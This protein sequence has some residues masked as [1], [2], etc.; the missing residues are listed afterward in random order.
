MVF[1]P[2]IRRLLS[3]SCVL[4]ILIISPALIE[5][6]T[7]RAQFIETF[8]DG[9]F[10]S[11]PAWIGEV[12]RW[13][14][15]SVDGPA[16]QSAG[17][18]APDTIYLA[19]ASAAS[20]GSWRFTFA[21]RGVNL[22][23]FNGARIFF[24]A[25][26]ADTRDA[27][28]GYY[29][30]LGTNNA[31]ALSLWRADGSLASQRTELGRSAVALLLGDSSWVDIVVER[32]V[33][34]RFRVFADNELVIS[35]TDSRHTSSAFFSVWVKHTAQAGAS[36]LLDDIHVVEEEAEVGPVPRPL[37]LVINE[38]LF[39]PLPGQSEFIE[40]HNRGESSF[41]L[42]ALRFRD[43]RSELLPLTYSSRPV[44]PGEFIVLVEDSLAFLT[45]IRDIPF[46][47]PETWPSLNNGGDA[48][49]LSGPQ[50]V[51]DSV[52]Y[53]GGGSTGGI[54]LER[55][56]P[57][58]PP[59][60]YNFS[61]SQDP[62]GST[63]GRVNSVFSIDEAGPAIRFVEEIAP[64]VLEVHFSEPIRVAEIAAA[65]VRYDDAVAELVALSDAS[66]QLTFD[67]ATLRDPTIE[68]RDVRD[69]KGNRSA[70][71][72]HDISFYPRPGDLSLNEIMFEP[73]ADRYDGR[74]DQVEFIELVNT[75][76]RRLSLTSL[77]RT[78]A[79]DEH[80]DA[81]T[82][83]LGRDYASA[84][85]GAYVVVS[86]DDSSA[87]R[88]AFPASGF[89]ADAVFVRAPGLT[90]PNGGDQIRIH[91]RLG[92]EIEAVMYLPE[93]HH[94]D[95]TVSRGMSLER[96][97]L[98]APADD[99]ASWSTSAAPDGATPGA[100]NSLAYESPPA[101]GVDRYGVSINPSPFS[102][103]GDGHEDAAVI[104]Y[105]LRA[106]APNIRVRIF[107]MEGFEVRSLQPAGL[108]G[109][110]GRL[111]WDGRGDG[112]RSLRVGVYILVF[113]AVDAESRAVEHF[114]LP[115]VLMRRFG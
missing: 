110:S 3:R 19:T 111:V 26:R 80:G 68:L 47:T 82:L 115:V 106:G 23:S 72:E 27:V 12:D 97:D 16:L 34:G 38:I 112:G 45:T 55:I 96:I 69:R 58:A 22:S 4:A 51:I 81:D 66:I 103:D 95:V 37:E 7:A 29:L 94:P 20:Y 79:V 1:L 59:E 52:R 6:G 70:A 32:D 57:E 93:W 92:D 60:P 25:D 84:P 42:R 39:D 78:R 108:S 88:N 90:L 56:D 107:D 49:I 43:D 104:T 33:F 14:I 46:I 113:E 102:P 91:N 50:G 86:D 18:A 44:A 64:G 109:S 65:S 21:H 13:T 99:A 10:D 75:S 62:A 8:D 31:D 15:G 2:S 30:Q 76:G 9:D 89:E 83:W 35:A 74:A 36:F 101:P 77:M 63:P 5:P 105:S 67:E 85:P 41:D 53:D 17:T 114:K 28:V 87:L 24:I 100:Q 11:N 73:A 54:S 98:A 40:L 48:V 71:V 61:T